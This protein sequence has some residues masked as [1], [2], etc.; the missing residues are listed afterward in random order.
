MKNIFYINVALFLV[1]LVGAACHELPSE[2]TG[3]PADAESD[4]GGPVA[5]GE[6]DAL[7]PEPVGGSGKGTHEAV[8]KGEV[9][10]VYRYVVHV[11]ETPSVKSS[12]SVSPRSASMPSVP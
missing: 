5:D 6:E 9:G 1:A 8:G 2:I 11:F 10:V 12:L 7:D 4:S 3:G